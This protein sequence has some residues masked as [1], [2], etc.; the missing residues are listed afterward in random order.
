MRCL[1]WPTILVATTN[2]GKIR[3][4][5]AALSGLPVHWLT[6]ADVAAVPEPDETGQT[7]AENARLK[8]HTYADAVQR[9]TVAEDSG[10]MI[11]ALDG[12]PGVLSARYPGDTYPE[13]FANLY[14]ELA[15]H[16]EPWLARFVSAL[17]F[18]VPGRRA[19]AYATEGVVTGRIERAPKGPN[20]FGYDPI[21]NYDG[22]GRTGG[23]LTDAEKLGVSHRGRAFANF[24]AWLEGPTS[25]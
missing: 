15:E 24:R 14:A 21:F 20:G 4:I 13:K 1:A 12:R 10:L 17:A 16:P 25:A 2:T 19:T 9:P 5:R 7:F 18:A 8:A 11:D 6:L 23:E 22:A 3:E